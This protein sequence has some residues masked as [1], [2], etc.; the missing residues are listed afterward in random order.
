[1][2]GEPRARAISTQKRNVTEFY[3]PSSLVSRDLISKKLQN[4]PIQKVFSLAI[5]KSVCI[6]CHVN[7][8]CHIHFGPFWDP[9]TANNTQAIHC[10]HDHGCP[11][12]ELR[13]LNPKS[14][15]EVL[16][17]QI[18]LVGNLLMVAR[19]AK[20]L[21][22][23]SLKWLLMVSDRLK[24]PELWKFL[25]AASQKYYPGCLP[26]L[27][28]TFGPKVQ[29]N[30]STTPWFIKNFKINLFWTRPFSSERERP[31]SSLKT[32][33]FANSQSKCFIVSAHDPTEWADDENSRERTKNCFWAVTLMTLAT[34]QNNEFST[35][36]DLDFPMDW[37]KTGQNQTHHVIE[38]RQNDKTRGDCFFKK[39]LFFWDLIWDMLLSD[40]QKIQAKSLGLE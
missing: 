34:R 35:K 38:H 19:G 21:D 12:L 37:D 14:S 39:F 31:S 10:S 26:C 40:D 25:I 8:L 6:S 9:W 33:N 28:E 15:L 4:G 17:I 22:S 13:T 24:Y 27:S 36:I 20:K 11:D 23:V 2:Q 5:L 3:F 18:N 16:K 7:Y 29:S 32:A 1:M 30:W